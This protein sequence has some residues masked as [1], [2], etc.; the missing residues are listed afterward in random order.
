MTEIAGY[1]TAE[2]KELRSK[3]SGRMGN[4]GNCLGLSG[5]LAGSDGGQLV[6]WS[7]IITVRLFLKCLWPRLRG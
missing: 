1:D 6:G 5:S 3:G 2:K 4:K 7:I